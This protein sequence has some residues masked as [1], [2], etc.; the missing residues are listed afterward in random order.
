MANPHQFRSTQSLTNE[1]G[2][3][4]YVRPLGPCFLI[5]VQVIKTMLHSLYNKVSSNIIISS[6]NQW[7]SINKK[8]PFFFWHQ[9]KKKRKRKRKRSCH[10]LLLPTNLN[11]HSPLKQVGFEAFR[12][13]IVASLSFNSSLSISPFSWS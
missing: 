8:L 13:A 5:H 2:M 6:I 1:P 9:K 4:I 7:T 10:W 12:R 3:Y 11:G